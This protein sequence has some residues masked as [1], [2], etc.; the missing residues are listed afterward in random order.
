MPNLIRVT[1][2]GNDLIL[3]FDDGS[4]QYGHASAGQSW[5]IAGSRPAVNPTPG[6]P[7]AT[8]IVSPLPSSLAVSNP[9]DGAFTLNAVQVQRAAEIL[10]QCLAQQATTAMQVIALITALTE[11][12][13]HNYSNVTAYPPS[14]SYPAPANADADGNNSDSV[15]M[16]Q[17]RP[18]A[19]WGTPQQC[20]TPAYETQA[21][22]G[23]ASGPNHGSP[24]GLL[25]VPGWAAMTPGEAAQAVQVSAYPTRYQAYV[26]TADQIIAALVTTTGG[27]SG[28]ATWQWPFQYSV[29]V[30]SDPLAQFGERIDPYTHLPEFHEG[31]DFGAAGIN[32][33]PI[34]VAAAGTVVEANYNSAQGNHVKV[35][36]AG[37]FD[38][39][40]FHMIALPPVVAG[41]VLTKGEIIGNVGMTGQATGPHLHWETH[42][43]GTPINP[44]QFMK[45]R[46]VP[47][48]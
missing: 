19:G 42:V 47:E 29:W 21:F 30:T 26:P 37:G 17:Q 33:K 4:K 24:R 44:R 48:S 6:A 12:T 16:F 43:N 23:G 7:T 11:S 5:I 36:H 20:M 1:Q 34:P 31:L 8:G 27:S 10:T 3:L 41:Q 40:Y 22:F 9:T 46:G 2:Q 28:S 39:W 38:T 25:D 32:G 35:S 18:A 14:S 13:L 15:G 45:D